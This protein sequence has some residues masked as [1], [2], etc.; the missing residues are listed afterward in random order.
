MAASTSSSALDASVSDLQRAL[1]TL[2]PELHTLTSSVPSAS[3]RSILSEAS[4]S[5]HQLLAFLSARKNPS[6]AAATAAARARDNGELQAQLAQLF[7]ALARAEGDAIVEGHSCEMALADVS[8]FQD[9]KVSPLLRDFSSV[10]ERAL[11]LVA[12]SARAVDAAIEEQG[13]SKRRVEANTERVA[14]TSKDL[15]EVQASLNTMAYQMEALVERRME[16]EERKQ[17]AKERREIQRVCVFPSI[18]FIAMS[19]HAGIVLS[20]YRFPFDVCASTCTRGCRSKCFLNVCPQLWHASWLVTD[21]TSRTMDAELRRVATQLASLRQ[22]TEGLNPALIEQALKEL[23][24][25]HAS[26]QHELDVAIAVVATLKAEKDSLETQLQQLEFVHEELDSV[27]Q[28]LAT[29]QHA[30]A[31][32]AAKAG[33]AADRASHAKGLCAQ[34]IANVCR[35]GFV[36]GR[37]W[38][39]ALL[40]GV[41]DVVGEGRKELEACKDDEQLDE[42]IESGGESVRKGSMISAD[43]SEHGDSPIDGT[44]ELVLP[45][46]IEEDLADDEAEDGDSECDCEGSDDEEVP[47]TVD[48]GVE[49]VVHA[50]EDVIAESNGATEIPL[51]ESSDTEEEEEEEDIHLNAEPAP[52]ETSESG[53]LLAYHDEEDEEPFKKQQPFSIKEPVHGVVAGSSFEPVA[54]ESQ[55]VQQHKDSKEPIVTVV[56]VD[57]TV[58]RDEAERRRRG[59]DMQ[60]KGLDV[61]HLTEVEVDTSTMPGGFHSPLIGH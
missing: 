32:S 50:E 10:K 33:D 11:A 44:G 45:P 26:L 39:V 54:S 29:A 42:G 4:E 47:E 41:V 38:I 52:S 25:E 27:C 56:E 40:S 59:L 30:V 6:A 55:P 37:R 7:A 15:D 43:W 61:V 3:I 46:T 12:D 57:E 5:L 51:P 19:D 14:A 17:E 13:E 53:P 28:Q 18:L 49:T 1:D 8:K 22:Q 16:L 9:A 23:N 2:Q 34:G 24:M 31:E 58:S 48:V 21:R 36:E 35:L 60:R 20:S